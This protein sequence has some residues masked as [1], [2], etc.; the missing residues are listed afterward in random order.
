[1]GIDT[2]QNENGKSV[3]VCN[4]TDQ[5]F[6]PVF[7][8]IDVADDFIDYCRRVHGSDPRQYDSSE[9]STV[10]GEFREC[11]SDRA[12]NRIFKDSHTIDLD[13]EAPV[14]LSEIEDFLESCVYDELFGS[15]STAYGKCKTSNVIRSIDWLLFLY[16]KSG[17]DWQQGTPSFE[18]SGND[19]RDC[20]RLI[21]CLA[22]YLEKAGRWEKWECFELGDDPIRKNGEVV[23]FTDVLEWTK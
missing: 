3:L 2:F 21:R 9:L 15:V 5:A 20:E 6:G 12:L 11:G 19:A 22:E 1:M 18:R 14:E 8:N 23:F 17:R 10:V 4:T 7:L 16:E 13:P